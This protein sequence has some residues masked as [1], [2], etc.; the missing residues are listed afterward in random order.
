MGLLKGKRILLGVTGS[1]AAYKSAIIVR[2]LVKAG[3]EVQVICTP[4][5][6]QF[7]TPLTLGTL[8]KHPVLDALVKDPEAGVWTNH[9]ELGLWADLML[10]APASAN[11]LSKMAHGEADNLLLTTYLSARCPVYFAPAMD[12][13]MHEHPANAENIQTLIQRGNIHIPAE[14]GELASGLEGKGRMAE[15]EHITSFLESYL[16]ESA[17]LREM[18][19]MITAGP[20]HE[21]IDPVRFIGNYSTGKMGYALAERALQ[22]GASVTLISGPTHLKSPAGA[23]V[24]NVHTAEEMH[25]A[26]KAAFSECNIAIFSAAVADFRPAQASPEKIKKENSV[27]V[28]HLEKTIDILHTLGNTKTGQIVVGFALETE[29]EEE[30]ARRKLVQKN[31]DIIVLNSL[32]DEGAGFGGDTNK[33]TLLSSNKTVPL[34]LMSKAD[35]AAGVFDFIIEEFL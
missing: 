17:P 9:V 7:V 2:E 22:L 5:A 24:V 28:I 14:S 23:T 35:T 34:K 13:D 15:P 18:K 33:V 30:N 27:P 8:S 11:T 1:I 32:R 26:A 20:T 31:A 6:L 10:V 12:H 21:P 29:N 25:A 3:S 4:S 16:L 19:V